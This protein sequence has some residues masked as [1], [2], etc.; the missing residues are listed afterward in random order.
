MSS[1]AWAR[2]GTCRNNLERVYESEILSI[3]LIKVFVI[4]LDDLAACIE[5]PVIVQAVVS[6][7]EELALLVLMLQIEANEEAHAR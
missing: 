5:H 4:D 3:C 7:D 6:L 2:E 1:L